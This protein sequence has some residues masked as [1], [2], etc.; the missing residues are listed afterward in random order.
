MV[1][2]ILIS[3]LLWSVW[4][5]MLRLQLT[6]INEDNKGFRYWL[7]T[8]LLGFLV[9]FMELGIAIYSG[10]LKKKWNRLI[11]KIVAWVDNE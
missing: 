10:T 3:L 1:A 5:F 2:I 9:L 11:R 4:G 6:D 7:M 8:C